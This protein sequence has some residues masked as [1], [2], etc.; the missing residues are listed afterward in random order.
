MAA[1]KIA[2]FGNHLKELR[3][4]LCQK[5]PQSQGVREFIENH[6]VPLKQANPRFPILIRECQGVQPVL[7]ARYEFGKE[8]SMSLA[9]KTKDQI[10]Q[11]ILTL[12]K[13]K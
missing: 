4:H 2:K 13:A 8:S 3:I 1:G 10:L 12:A 6:Y 5:S 7:Y 11:E 9:S